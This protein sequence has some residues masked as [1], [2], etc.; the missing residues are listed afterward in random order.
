MNAR[1]PRSR[2]HKS[3]TALA[4]VT[5]AF[6][7]TLRYQLIYCITHVVSNSRLDRVNEIT[8]WNV[9][10][11]CLDTE[12]LAEAT[13][14]LTLEYA[15]RWDPTEIVESVHELIEHPPLQWQGVWT[16]PRLHRAAPY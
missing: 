16:V 11:L 9:Q 7:V 6:R 1:V 12:I 14:H 15:A 2:R 3:P 8:S 10:G 13:E 4:I 5:Y